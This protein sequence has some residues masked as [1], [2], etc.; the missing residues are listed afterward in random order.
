VGA[1][2]FVVF[3]FWV[4]VAGMKGMAAR[5]AQ[6]GKWLCTPWG[7]TDDLM[8]T[9]RG[10]IG[11]SWS[12]DEYRHYSSLAAQSPVPAIP[13]V[14]NGMQQA[15]DQEKRTAKQLGH[16]IAEWAHAIE[17]LNRSVDAWTEKAATALAAGRNDLA[18]AAIIERQRT[19]ERVK[20][21]ESD[22]VDMRRLLTTHASDIQ[23]LESKLSTVYRRNHLAETRLSAAE[24]S[25]RAREMLY[26]EHVKD[27]L[28]RFEQLERAADLA[29][30]HADSLAL[31]SE[32]SSDVTA[33]D[34]ELAALRPNAG[35]GRKRI[36]S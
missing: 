29:E 33:I 20:D 2:L 21:L 3:W 10:P 6:L 32:S 4:V 8:P 5:C 7:N 16:D 23:S 19:Q 26:G 14:M 25:A 28:S 30:G 24:T 34:A 31:G 13:E 11:Q 35:F 1:L 36:A 9:L 18:R 27:A 15:L 17:Q 22:V 12:D